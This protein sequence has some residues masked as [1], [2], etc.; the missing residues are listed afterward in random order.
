MFWI[1][2]ARRNSV[3]LGMAYNAPKSIDGSQATAGTAYYTQEQLLEAFRDGQA[4]TLLETRQSVRCAMRS[5]RRLE[6]IPLYIGGKYF[7]DVKPEIIKQEPYLRSAI[8]EIWLLEDAP[9]AN[10]MKVAIRNAANH[11]MNRW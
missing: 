9:L 7:E 4:D 10:E 5:L 8:E 6:I 3:L 1:K 11:G 2:R